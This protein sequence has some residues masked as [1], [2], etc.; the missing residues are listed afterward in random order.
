MHPRSSHWHLIDFVL[1]RQRD[2][3]N[4]RLTRAMRATS[5]W[6]DHRMVRTSVFL[7]TKAVKRTHRAVRMKRLDVTKLKDEA[8]CLALEEQLDEALAGMTR[9]N[10][11][12]SSLLSTILQPQLLGSA[13]L[14]TVTGSTT[15]M[16]KPVSC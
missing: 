11:H 9:T 16:P 10:G 1:T 2:L 12:S 5:S 14:A 15:K 8:T 4:I 3:R 13:R 6:S 7:T